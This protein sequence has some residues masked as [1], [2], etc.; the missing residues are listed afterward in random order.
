MGNLFVG[1]H[2]AINAQFPIIAC[3]LVS[4]KGIQ[5]LKK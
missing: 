3:I 2:T 5:T 4:R 1:N